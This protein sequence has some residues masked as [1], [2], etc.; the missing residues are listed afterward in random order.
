M[1]ARDLGNALSESLTGFLEVDWQNEPLQ[2]E[3][4]MQG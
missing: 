3:A 2:T 1:F 4:R